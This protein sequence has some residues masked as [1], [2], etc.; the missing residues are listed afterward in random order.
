[1][2][3]Q[4]HGVSVPG[5]TNKSYGVLTFVSRD[6]IDVSVA[7][8]FIRTFVNAYKAHG[9]IVQTTQPPIMMGTPEIG[10]GVQNLFNK[11][12]ATCKWTFHITQ[13]HVS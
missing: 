5:I 11:V 12:V 13:I 2:H 7:Q 10:E 4:Q 1:V 9:G 8:N 6:H 3:F